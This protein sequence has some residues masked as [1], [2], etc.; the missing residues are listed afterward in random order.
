M[1]LLLTAMSQFEEQANVNFFC[2][3]GKSK[4]ET[5]VSLRAAYG[6]EALKKIY[7]VQTSTIRVHEWPRITTREGE[8]KAGNIKGR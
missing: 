7:R 4:L 2:K 3:L 8:Q 1:L 6:N 5:P